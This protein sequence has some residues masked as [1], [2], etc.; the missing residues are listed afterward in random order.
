MAVNAREIINNLISNPPIP[1][2]LK[3]GKVTVR[4]HNAE[5]S[6]QMFDYVVYRIAYNLEDE[7]TSPPRRT[8]VAWLFV[9]APRISDEELEGKTASQIEELWKKRFMDN[10]RREFQSAVNI[11]LANRGVIR[12]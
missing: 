11:Y 4:I 2:S 6:M 12:G 1:K 9:S 8:P 10:L 5:I 7:E 3:F